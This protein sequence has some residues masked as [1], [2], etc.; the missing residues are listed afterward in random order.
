MGGPNPRLQGSITAK[1]V[2]PLLG[3]NL[4]EGEQVK[5][6]ILL[7]IKSDDRRYSSFRV[8]LVSDGVKFKSFKIDL[9]P[10]NN[11]LTTK[12]SWFSRAI[13]PEKN[14]QIVVYGTTADE[15]DEQS[16]ILVAEF[17]YTY[18]VLCNK[19]T[20]WFTNL[21]RTMSRICL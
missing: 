2:T 8:I 16:E 18:R 4:N 9:L 10:G 12:I 11:L 13:P 17:L 5:V 19:S 20:S 6:S 7:K 1:D 15:L 21:Y 14:N 3:E